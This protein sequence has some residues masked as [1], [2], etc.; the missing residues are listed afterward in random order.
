MGLKSVILAI[1]YRDLAFFKRWISEYLVLWMIP[2]IFS[3]A[4][5]FLPAT[6]FESSAVV[7]RVSSVLGAKLSLRDVLL[8][9]ITQSALISLTAVIMEETINT[10]YQEKN[11]VGVLA[12]VL[13]SVSLRTYLACQALVK[14]VVLSITSTLYLAVVLPLIGGLDGLV[15]YIYILPAL[16]VTGIALGFY[17]LIIAIPLT[18]YTKISRPWTITNTLI[19]ALLA[20][21]GL[22]IPLKFV[23]IVLRA[24]AYTA[25]LPHTCEV[26]RVIALK[27]FSSQLATP[28]FLITILL[29]IYVSIDTWLTNLSDRYV[30]S[31]GV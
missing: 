31:S 27:G 4:V 12:T 17:G 28:M 16:I 8:Y 23:P 26:L 19:P 15:L 3:L 10:L 13:E 9:A 5:V 18:F 11:F 21:S 24:L 6:L 20:G 14:P 1:L 29:A 2:M 7:Q 22:Y 25:P 30:R